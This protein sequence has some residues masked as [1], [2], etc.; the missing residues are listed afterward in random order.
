VGM[1]Q[2]FRAVTHDRVRSKCHGNRTC[3]PNLNRRSRSPR[4][5]EVQG[6]QVMSV[7]ACI[8]SGP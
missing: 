7:T 4:S 5:L 3:S 6:P 2:I 8:Q 1:Q